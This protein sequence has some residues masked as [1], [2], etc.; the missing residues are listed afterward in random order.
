MTG[1][2]PRLLETHTCR[3]TCIY[4]RTVSLYRDLGFAVDWFTPIGY[5]YNGRVVVGVSV[6]GDGP[7]RPV[8]LLSLHTLYKH[9]TYIIAVII[10]I[11]NP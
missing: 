1:Q 5:V 9:G 4:T 11:L 8:L 6:C 7:D 2:P 3:R 10:L